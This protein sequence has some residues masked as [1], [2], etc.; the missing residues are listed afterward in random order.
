MM[1]YAQFLVTQLREHS[2]ENIAGQMKAYLK[3]EYAFFGVQA[4]LRK[5]LFRQ[6]RSDFSLDNRQDYEQLVT[7]LWLSSHRE[8]QYQA[9]EVAQ[10]Y[11]PWFT[12][13]SMPLYEMMLS[14]AESWDTVDWLAISII[15]PLLLLEPALKQKMSVW[16]NSDNV[17]LRRSAV[18]VHNKHKAQTDVTLLSE[19]ILCLAHDK[20]FFIRKAIGWALREYSRTDCQWVELFVEQNSSLLS[21]LSQREALKIINKK[22]T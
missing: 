15:G 6:A 13:D 12:P 21:P 5:K 11:K 17:W 16:R 7:E 2:D 1:A 20:D 19:T 22:K 9:L 10:A 8:T 18:I 3:S 4:P 14:S